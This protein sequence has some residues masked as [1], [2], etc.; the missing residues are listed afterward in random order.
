KDLTAKGAKIAEIKG[1]IATFDLPDPSKWSDEDFKKINELPHL[2]RLGF[3]LKFNAH[4]LSLLT[5]LSDVTLIGTNG[6][7]L[8]DADI[9]Q[10]TRF[11]KLTTLAF[12]HPGKSLT[13]PGLADLATLPSFES[14][15]VG[16][17]STFGNDGMAAIAKLPHLKSFR[18]WH[19]NVDVDGL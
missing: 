5:E 14:L 8:S 11:K 4:Q 15:T 17:S 16:G 1:V 6:A 7:D 10:F 13:G 18:V 3:G 12:F 19:T 2:Q 9:K